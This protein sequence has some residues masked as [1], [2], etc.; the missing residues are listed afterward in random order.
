MTDPES[1]SSSAPAKASDH[2]LFASTMTVATV[3]VLVFAKSV[4]Y[5]FSD[6]AAVLASLVDSLTDIGL[7]VMTFLAIRLSHKPADETHRHG[8]GKIEA[9]SALMQAAF[10]LGGATFLVFEGF[11][12]LLKPQVLSQHVFALVL[13]GFATLLSVAMVM[14]QK[15]SL[16]KHKSIALEAD[17]AH[18]S[19]DVWI[20]L[21]TM[22]VV[23]LSY[24]QILPVWMDTVCALV[25]AGLMVHAARDIGIKALHVLMDAEL[26]DD[27][28]LKITSII[29]GTPD[30]LG[31]HDLRTFESG[32]KIFISFDMEV[33]PNILLWSAHEIARTVEH[34]LIKVYPTAEIL[35][36]LDP[37]GDTADTRHGTHE[38]ENI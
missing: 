34:N 18:Y 5:I 11:D 29:L 23:F 38:G 6:S 25:I 15:H 33:D 2:P 37:E 14:V 1:P 28:R 30:V 8:H 4:A 21:S 17:H 19:A 22:L 16:K 20:N 7:S 12:R 9:V 27:I 26:S 13:M 35:I 31:M 36:H 10:L 3:I 32:K 24:K